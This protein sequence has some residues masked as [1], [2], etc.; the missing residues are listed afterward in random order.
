MVLGLAG[1]VA[2]GATLGVEAPRHARL[3]ETLE[4]AE[5]GRAP[6]RRL[7]A[8]DRVVELGGRDLAA[9]R[10]EGGG[11]RQALLGDALARRGEPIGGRG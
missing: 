1:D 6:D 10:G 2:R 3:D 11:D 8:P 4:G 5:H 7:A 9:R